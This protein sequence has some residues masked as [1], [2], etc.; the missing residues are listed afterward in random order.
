MYSF[1]AIEGNIGAGKTTLSKALAEANGAQ[2][3]LEEFAEN[4]FLPKF[5]QEKDK[6]A[7]ALELSFLAARYQQINSVVSN[8]DLFS[9]GLIAD[10]FFLKS[11]L[12]ASVTL[13]EDEYTLFKTLFNII[14]INLP[15][16]DILIFINT[17]IKQLMKNIKQRG[18][19]YEQ[20]IEEEYLISIQNTYL[21]FFKQI[22]QYPIII[23]QSKGDLFPDVAAIQKILNTNY[24]PGLHYIA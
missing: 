6:H 21:S 23:V 17:P 2:L 20:N 10:Y 19:S 24:S 5:Y 1:V 13:S 12:F 15:S 16:P 11:L 22:T 4:P 9:N 7:F 18:R 8:R 14:N 3:I